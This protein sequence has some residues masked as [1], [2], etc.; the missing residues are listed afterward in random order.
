RRPDISDR[1]SGASDSQR[2][3]TSRF[4]EMGSSEE[5]WHNGCSKRVAE[6]FLTRTFIVP[7]QL[8]T[9][10]P[11]MTTKAWLGWIPVLAVA[12]VGCAGGSEPSGSTGGGGDTVIVPGTLCDDPSTGGSMVGGGPTQGPTKGGFPGFSPFPP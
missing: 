12:A 11:T 3:V 10:A 5:R 2:H 9:E 6:R 8:P 4:F 1:P 7:R